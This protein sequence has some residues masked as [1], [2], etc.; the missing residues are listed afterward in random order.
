MSR[1]KKLDNIFPI[2]G[3]FAKGHLQITFSD[4]IHFK[5]WVDKEKEGWRKF[6]ISSNNLR[7]G[8]QKVL[9]ILETLS[10]RYESLEKEDIQNLFSEYL[11][12]RNDSE[13]LFDYIASEQ[14]DVFHFT[15]NHLM[16]SGDD[17]HQVS[18]NA[19]LAKT[20]AAIYK[21]TASLPDGLLK[22]VRHVQQ[23]NATL[24]IQQRDTTKELQSNTAKLSTLSKNLAL[25]APKEYWTKRADEAKENYK[26][27]N[28]LW[29]LWVITCIFA[30]IVISSLG[31]KILIPQHQ[32]TGDWLGIVS[33]ISHFFMLTTAIGFIVWF[34]RTLLRDARLNQHL[35]YDAN[36]RVT[37]L[38][39][40]VAMK[41]FG[42]K[43]EDTQLILAALFRPVS[44]GGL[45]DGG[46]TLFYE[47]LL[48]N[49]NPK[50]PTN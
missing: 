28:R 36:E 43:D 44:V 25:Q 7:H 22:T 1:D 6:S 24:S 18:P 13:V 35:Y 45:D 31:S 38:E 29:T 50:L 15:L 17:N 5:D 8:Y 20:Y 39:T 47:L 33:L 4:L 34:S 40:F 26:L 9:Q 23:E 16:Q 11:P 42:L 46:P 19:M 41:E 2:S 12:L 27:K 48:K 49:I 37:M 21:V 14:P 3:K 30:A 32:T 10:V